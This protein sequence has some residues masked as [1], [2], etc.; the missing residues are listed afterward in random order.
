MQSFHHR[1]KEK[2]RFGYGSVSIETSSE[3]NWPDGSWRLE[4]RPKAQ[5]VTKGRNVES[6]EYVNCKKRLKQPF[7]NLWFF[8]WEENNSCLSGDLTQ[9]ITALSDRV[10]SWFI[11][12]SW[13][14]DCSL[15]PRRAHKPITHYV[16]H[17]ALKKRTIPALNILILIQYTAALVTWPFRNLLP[18]STMLLRFVK[19][20]GIFS[21]QVELWRAN[22]GTIK[23]TPRFD[24]RAENVPR[25][26]TGLCTKM[27]RFRYIRITP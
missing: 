14:R 12:N 13:H 11:S 19:L 7:K 6:D 25:F 23:R 16:T 18:R 24:F 22:T 26:T 21:F 27:K 3:K 10:K 4:V 20:S 5:S 1:K 15:W 2:D 17:P 8:F 9:L